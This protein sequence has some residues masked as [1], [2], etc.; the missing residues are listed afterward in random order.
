MVAV[1]LIVPAPR[2]LIVPPDIFAPPLTLFVIVPEAAIVSV[3]ALIANVPLL[4][5]VVTVNAPE[6]LK[7][8]LLLP[9]IV[10]VVAALV[11]A[12]VAVTSVLIVTFLLTAGTTVPAHVLAVF[13]SAL[14]LFT[15]KY[16]NLLNEE[17][18][19][20]RVL[21]FVT[22]I[23]PVVAPSGI[24]AVIEIAELTVTLVAA[25]PLKLTVAPAA[26]F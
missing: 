24:V 6:E 13:Q 21:V 1:P 19:P 8:K 12:P 5:T 23:T 25:V 26:K 9:F 22:V 17:E 14:E 3:P 15:D 4:T 16:P 10:T 20:E 7:V 11:T 2:K 18:L